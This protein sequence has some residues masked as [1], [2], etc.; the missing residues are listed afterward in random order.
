MNV[1]SLDDFS[2]SP[3]SSIASEDTASLIVEESINSSDSD[4]KDLIEAEATMIEGDDDNITMQSVASLLSNSSTNSSGRLEQALRQAAKQAGTQGIEFDEHGDLS[5]EL[6]VGETLKVSDTISHQQYPQPVDRRQFDPIYDQENVNPFSPAFRSD[7]VRKIQEA[8]SGE[9]MDITQA[10]GVML[11]MSSKHQSPSKSGRRKYVPGR[12]RSDAGRRRS[13]DNESISVDE[14]MDLTVAVGGIQQI[15]SI[16][17]ED[18]QVSLDDEDED[19]DLSMEFTSVVG[20]V[21]EHHFPDS[22]LK[23]QVIGK[24]VTN[25][26]ISLGE[27]GRTS[28]SSILSEE[29]MDMTMAMGGILPSITER[30]EPNEDETMAMDVT[31]AM[32]NILPEDLRTNDRMVAKQLME[33]EAEHGQLTRSMFE[34]P[35]QV[36][37]AP[38]ITA[39]VGDSHLVVFASE[40]GSPSVIIAHGHNSAK[41][42]GSRPSVAPQ[43]NIN[44]STPLKGPFTPSKKLTPQPKRPITPSKTPPSKNVTLRS[45]SP[46]KLFKA[47]IKKAKSTTPN[48]AIPVLKFNSSASTGIV[49]PN[50]ILTP[51]NSRTSGIGIDKAGLGSPRIAAL[52]DRRASIGENAVFNRQSPAATRI[53]FEDPYVMEQE[54][55]SERLEDE[56]RESGKGIL[57]IEVDG[58]YPENNVTANLKDKIESL[59]PKKKKLN[60]RKSLHVGAARGLLGKRP[61]ELD[62]EESDESTPKRLRGPN[63][64]PVK[65]IRLPPPPSKT[66]TTGRL[67][68]ALRSSLGET[69][70]NKQISTPKLTKGSLAPQTAASPNHQGRFRDAELIA[71]AGKPATTFNEKLAGMSSVKEPTKDE[72]GMHLQGFLNMTSIRFMDITTTKRRHTVA[73]GVDHDDTISGIASHDG[74]KHDNSSALAAR[75]VAAA[76]TVPMLELYEHV[77]DPNGLES[78]RNAK[79]DSVLPRTENIHLRRS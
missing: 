49:A 22:K 71:S 66:E 44:E 75:V 21:V 79:K 61:A 57:E 7:V 58:E 4:E 47:E 27:S 45:A 40:L 14:T 32:G 65:N 19:E 42:E 38:R 62:E 33:Q 54:V 34:K 60:G 5:M 70:A 68:N 12:R 52:L 13:S 15:Q 18:H 8:N 3:G 59:T 1:N 77:S 9:A 25:Q 17:D 20:G 76:C 51:Q 16:V 35:Q 2:S 72:E 48:S 73:P 30:T 6:T 78:P 55:D 23:S 29:D 56:R 69:T 50:I 67:K 10:P 46:K 41:S 37:T 26:H 31:T 64:S 24:M 74:D 63:K 39:P 43:V 11:S 53:R 28:I 36:E